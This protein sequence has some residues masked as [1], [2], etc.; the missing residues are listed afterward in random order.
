MTDEE[1][2]KIYEDMKKTF[3]DDLDIPNPE[4]SPMVFEYFLRVFRYYESLQK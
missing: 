4:H 1:M 2:M 3:G